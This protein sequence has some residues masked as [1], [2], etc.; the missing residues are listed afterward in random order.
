MTVQVL[1]LN[2]EIFFPLLCL[3]LVCFLSLFSC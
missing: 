1:D 2:W 3:T